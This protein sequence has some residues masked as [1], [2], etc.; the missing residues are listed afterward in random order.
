MA[1]SVSDSLDLTAEVQVFYTRPITPE[2]RQA[3]ERL[4]ARWLGRPIPRPV[5]YAAV[6]DSAIPALSRQPGVDF[7][8]ARAMACDRDLGAPT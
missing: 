8:R 4:G 3:V 5:L 1:S 6:P 7:V 2:D